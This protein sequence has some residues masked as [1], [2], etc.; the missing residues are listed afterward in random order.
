MKVSEVLQTIGRPIAYYPGLA[1][2]L[3]GVKAVVLFCQ[4]FYWQ[5]KATSALGVY[6][7]IDELIDETGL[8]YDEVR[9]ARRSLKACGVLVET[10]K[11]LEH[12]TYYRIDEEALERVVQASAAGAREVAARDDE[13]RV[14]A[15]YPPTPRAPASYPQPADPAEGETQD[16]DY[17]NRNN[18]RPSDVFSAEFLSEMGKVHFANCE[19]SISRSGESPFREMDFSHVVNGAEITGIDY[20]QQQLARA[21]E[22]DSPSAMLLPLPARGETG[23][24]P[25]ASPDDPSRA[26][27]FAPAVRLLQLLASESAWPCVL[28]TDKDAPRLRGWIVRQVTPVVLREAYRRAVAARIRDGQTNALNVGFVDRFVEEV[29]AGQDRGAPSATTP[30]DLEMPWWRGGDDLLQATGARYGVPPRPPDE[31]VPVYRVRVAEAAGKGPWIAWII[32]N[33][34][35]SGSSQ[36]ENFVMKRLSGLLEQAETA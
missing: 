18:V 36:F 21:H 16:V 29:L 24:P 5:D 30:T 25:E 32:D 31:P 20:R 35:R 14:A 1:K 13:Q 10:E 2:P 27:A 9:A 8:T 28:D 7:N 12:K 19:K 4:I 23:P 3:G 11:R 33:A 15:G 26:D 6:K 34:R 22:A 17:G